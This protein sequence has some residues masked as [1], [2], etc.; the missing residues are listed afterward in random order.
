MSEER[1][2]TPY[3]Q[4]H[5]IRQLLFVTT[6][7]GDGQADAIVAINNKYEVAMCCVCNGVG[8]APRRETLFEGGKK[9]VVF[10]IMRAEK[11]VSYK[12]EI[13]Q[14]FAVSKM[15]RGLCFATPLDS[16]AGISIYKMLSN[17]RNFEKPTLAT[18]KQE[19]KKH[20]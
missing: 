13:Q 8:T 18:K 4:T 19:K 16:V 3:E 12:L 5:R 1:D 17:T 9:N 2:Y 11:W 14:R 6:I 10:S 20:E 15:A 7:V